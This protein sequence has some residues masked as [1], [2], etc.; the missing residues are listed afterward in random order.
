[1]KALILTDNGF[2]DSELLYPYYRLRELGIDVKIASTDKGV[3]CGKIGYTV[4]VDLTTEDVNPDDFDILILPG[5]KG[6][7]KVRQDKKAV[8][9]VKD[10]DEKKKIIGAI[11]H[12]PQL[13]ISA[14]VLNGRKVTSY[15]G[16]KDDI[17]LAGAKFSDEKVAVDDNIITSRKPEDLPFFMQEIIKKIQIKN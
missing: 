8:N 6:P 9:I 13:L 16:I 12:G 11:C 3:L 7:E 14:D 4:E 10:F 5:G 1:M 17:I 15:S 2:E